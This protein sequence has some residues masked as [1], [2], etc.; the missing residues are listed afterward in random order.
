MNPSSWV[1]STAKNEDGS[2]VE[3]CG[4]CSGGSFVSV[5]DVFWDG[6]P[7]ENLA[8]GPDGKPITFISR[9]QKAAYLKEKGLYEAGDKF[10]GA[11]FTSIMKEDASTRKRRGLAEVAEAR[12]KVQQMGQDVRRQAILKVIHDARNYAGGR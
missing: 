8:D 12:R 11:P 9:G 5:P 2:Y 3:W 6:R 10:H 1:T 4:V 7:E